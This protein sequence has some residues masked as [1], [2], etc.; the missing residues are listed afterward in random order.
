MQYFFFHLIFPCAIFFFL[1]FVPFPP[2]SSFNGSSLKKA[3]PSLAKFYEIDGEI[4]EAEQKMYASFRRV[5]WLG[6]MTVPDK[7]LSVFLLEQAS[8]LKKVVMRAGIVSV[9][10]YTYIL[11]LNHH[12]IYLISFNYHIIYM[13]TFPLRSIFRCS[14]LFSLLDLIIRL[15]DWELGHCTETNA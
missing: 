11:Y 2:I 3:S 8:L 12:F 7:Y 4:L 1:Y 5:R 15:H 13:C 10:S 6:Y 9:C 14:N